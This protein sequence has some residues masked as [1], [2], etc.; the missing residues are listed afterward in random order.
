MPS[1]PNIIVFCQC[2]AVKSDDIKKFLTVYQQWREQYEV[3]DFVDN[4]MKLFKPSLSRH[5]SANVLSSNASTMLSRSSVDRDFQP[6][7]FP[8]PV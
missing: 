8:S 4:K 7:Y 3:F 6:D 5:T 1:S 2:L